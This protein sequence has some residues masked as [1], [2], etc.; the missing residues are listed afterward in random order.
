M[1][2]RSRI[3]LAASLLGLL[4]LSAPAFA[5]QSAQGWCQA[6][7]RTVTTSGL[8]STTLVQ[9]SAPSCT[10]TVNV[11][12]GGLATIFAD[13]AGTA[14]A[15]PFTAASNGQ[16]TW[17]ADNG[18]YSVVT[19]GGTPTLPS[20]VTYPDILLDD[21]SSTGFTYQAVSFSATPT[22]N[23]GSASY[24]VMNPLTGNVTSSSVSGSPVGGSLIGF[25][26]C[27]DGTGS[28]TF[29]WPG[30]FTRPPT[31]SPIASS[32]TQA[33][34]V[35][36]SV[37]ATW[38]VFAPP[39]DAFTSVLPTTCGANSF[40]NTIAEQGGTCAQP[41]AANLSNGTTGSGAVVLATSPAI[42]TPTITSP[43][44]ITP[45]LGA[46]TG[47]S[48]SLSSTL[49]VTG[50]STL[51]AVTTTGLTDSGNASVTGTLG[52][53]GA[54]TAAS[55][56]L[57]ASGVLSTTAQSGTGSLCMTVNCVMTTPT[58]GA[59]SGTSLALG[60]GTALTT[61][62]RTGTGNL[63]LATAP[64]IT[65]STQDII[66]QPAATQFTLKDNQGGTRY[67]IPSGGGAQATLNNTNLLAVG[68]S[69]SVTL[70]PTGCPPQG[71]TGSI[72]G[73]GAPA[74]L[75]TCSLPAN[76][77]ALNKVLHVVCSGFHD[78]GTL[79]P[80]L[81]IVINGQIVASGSIGTVASQSFTLEIRILNT[82]ATTGEGA[83]SAT[84][85]G[86]YIPFSPS[87]TGL[88]WASIQTLACQFTVTA[89]D[90]VTGRAWIPELSQ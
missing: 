78:T 60:G 83:G 84:S 59:A 25:Q 44:L 24:F 10:V 54:A 21:T 39:G 35:F 53:T 61:T 81:S 29:A 1:T 68:N 71:N 7:G 74:N 19:S 33:S 75:Y 6:G 4:L 80:L 17:Y 18:H 65:N 46:A 77:V 45:V 50:T 51:G 30:N 23:V 90:H 89:G 55:L 47:T 22:F 64:T 28:R 52:V 41:S 62:N 70:L 82:G 8:T 86:A 3:T 38:R 63:V 79:N 34:F 2:Q 40:L 20:S 5:R 56:N 76:T 31:I 49:G 42:T 15:N 12:G 58:L 85:A 88:A 9:Q 87:V 73:T 26:L 66:N 67:S 48:L 11:V 14:L 16:W 37:S 43:T 57:A 27:Q 32:C 36:D 72:N 13:N 69:N